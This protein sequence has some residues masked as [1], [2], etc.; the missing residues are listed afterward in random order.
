MAITW[1]N[2]KLLKKSAEQKVV[3]YNLYWDFE[4]GS[5]IAARSPFS[6]PAAAAVVL[7]TRCNSCLG[8]AVTDVLGGWWFSDGVQG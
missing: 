7:W 3:Y 8:N 2:K 1:E 6:M 4:Y 5:K